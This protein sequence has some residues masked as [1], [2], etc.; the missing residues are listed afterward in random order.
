[1]LRATALVCL[2]AL[3]LLAC[4]QG[5]QGGAAEDV[6]PAASPAPAPV[7]TPTPP[8]LSADTSSAVSTVDSLLPPAF[9]GAGSPPVEERIYKSDAVV[10]ATFL[11]AG[12]YSLRF[13][14]IE[15]L[16]GSGP[17]KITVSGDPLLRNIDYDDR[18][19]ILFLSRASNTFRFSTAHYNAP[20]YTIDTLD[21]AWLP[22]EAANTS[23]VSSDAS[24]D[25][26]ITDSGAASKMSKETVSLA[27]LKTKIAWVGGGKNVT[28]Y[29]YCILSVV[30]HL[31]FYRDYEAYYGK[32]RPI[33]NADASL[34]SGAGAGTVVAD[35]GEYR[36]DQGYG[37]FWLTGA[38]SALFSAPIVDS[39]TNASDGYS[40]RIETAR[41]LPSG[42]YKFRFHGTLYDYIPCNFTPTEGVG[43]SNWTV[44]VT[45][46]AGTLHEAFFDP[47]P[48]GNAVQADA[49]TGVLKPRAFT[50]ASSAPAAIQRIAYQAGA[51]T[52]AV[53][54]VD[55][56][57][58]QVVEFIAM[59]GAVTLSLPVAD[60]SADAGGGTLRWPASPAPWASGDKLML[61]IRADAATGASPSD[62]DK[63]FLLDV[64][65]EN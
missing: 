5:E 36:G 30:N 20:G 58:G 60:A 45:A 43:G 55:A 8:S 12:S 59:D 54:P 7:P 57:A 65:R 25:T 21:P 48:V 50:A 51:V 29:D 23:G 9:Y 6:A 3:A 22:A 19:A 41:P 53:S 27:D 28:G 40:N 11:E 10:R 46:P 2:V 1:M 17:S 37:R 38:D 18:E 15:Y 39:N 24:S 44:T 61:R 42:T 62:D 52:I 49:E 31:S 32:A 34:L 16:K 35:Y 56:L 63:E 64:P 47:V 33:P 26:F 13:S 14:V 4:G